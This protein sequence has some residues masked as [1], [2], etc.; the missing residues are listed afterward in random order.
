MGKTHPGKKGVRKVKGKKWAPS[1]R[2]ESFNKLAKT[3]RSRK[4]NGSK[5]K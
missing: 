3:L 1:T 4:L 2:P 5:V